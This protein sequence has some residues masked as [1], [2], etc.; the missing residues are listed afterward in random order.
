MKNPWRDWLSKPLL[1]VVEVLFDPSGDRSDG[2]VQD[3][4][5]HD[6]R[7]EHHV[8]LDVQVVVKVLATFDLLVLDAEAGLLIEGHRRGAG[9]DP[10]LAAQEAG[11]ELG[12]V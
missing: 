8:L 3:R 2:R 6:H 9:G 4:G 1:E 5:G 10:G 11:V 12:A 7:L